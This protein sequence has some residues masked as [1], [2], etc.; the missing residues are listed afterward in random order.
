MSSLRCGNCG[1]YG[2]KKQIKYKVVQSIIL[3]KIYAFLCCQHC[4]KKEGVLVSQFGKINLES[5]EQLDKLEHW[6]LKIK[7]KKGVIIRQ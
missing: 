2:N 1:M 5:Q 3:E 6:D 4:N 7:T